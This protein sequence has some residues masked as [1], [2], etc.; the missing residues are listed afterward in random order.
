MEYKLTFEDGSD[1]YLSHHGVLGMK[2]GVRNAETQA[3]YAGAQG[4][5]ARKQDLKGSRHRQRLKTNAY[6]SEYVQKSANVRSAY[7]TGQISKKK[8]RA[9]SIRNADAYEKDFYKAR[10]EGRKERAIIKSEGK[11]DRAKGRIMGRAAGATAKEKAVT[12]RGAYVRRQSTGKRAAKAVLL[13][14]SG[15]TSYNSARAAGKNRL[16]S[17]GYA[18]VGNTI[19]GAYLPYD[20]YA[21]RQAHLAKK[22]T[23]AKYQA[24]RLDAKAK[25]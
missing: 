6:A 23:K 4:R 14:A 7:K 13:G 17:M 9:L 1:G 15:Y 11:S 12:Q 20:A 19:G 10:A 18:A 16:T 5:T 25:R 2:W 3:K 22:A 24:K 8:A 21:G